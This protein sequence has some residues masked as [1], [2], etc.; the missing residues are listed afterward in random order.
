MRRFRGLAIAGL[1]LVT[2]RLALAQDGAPPVA[3]VPRAAA[4][5]PATAAA[6]AIP[7]NEALR[8]DEYLNR[9]DAW[10]NE[11]RITAAEAARARRLLNAAVVGGD[12]SVHVP[13]DASGQI[14]LL[15][16]ARGP[17]AAG[18]SGRPEER[19]AARVLNE[20]DI[21][22][23]A[24]ARDLASPGRVVLFQ[25]AYT[26][27]PARDLGRIVQGALETTPI[28]E[29]PFGAQL[30]QAIHVLPNAN[31]VTTGQTFREASRLVGDRQRDWMELRVGRIVQG[32]KLEGSLL[33]FGAITALRMKSPGAA[34][35]MDGL[36]MRLRV[37]QA[38]SSDRRL[39]STGRLVYR[40]AHPLPDLELESGTRHVSGSATFRLTTTAALGVDALYRASGRMGIGTRWQRGGLFADTNATYAFPGNL[41]RTEFRG[42]YLAATGLAVSA[43]V[44]ATFG[45]GSGAIGPANGRLGF[46]LD[47]TKPLLIGGAPGETSL[48]VSSGAD[49]DFAYADWRG[50]L[51]FR[52]RF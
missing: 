1:V 27:V 41:A 45:R 11:G 6:P 52:L 48:F 35:F 7:A 32:H 12:R 39:Y 22:M 24:R 34:R 36:G 14:D 4:A 47:L 8:L 31:A 51:V 2:A 15:G 30:V 42:G 5:A 28:G 46:E 23:Q 40:N 20:F 10:R 50:G 16:L 37:W 26:A 17:A 13:L 33:A 29:L 43:A 9:L 19:L 49:S 38:S 21:R 44:A 25:G 18:L 3:D